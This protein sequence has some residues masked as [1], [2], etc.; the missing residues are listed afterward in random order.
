MSQTTDILINKLSNLSPDTV[1]Q[2]SQ[3]ATYQSLKQSAIELLEIIGHDQDNLFADLKME[4]PPAA[5]RQLGSNSISFDAVAADNPAA[6]A[7][8]ALQTFEGSRGLVRSGGNQLSLAGRRHIV[9]CQRTSRAK[10]TVLVSRNYLI[11]QDDETSRK[12]YDLGSLDKTDALEV[13]DLLGKPEKYPKGRSLRFPPGHH[14]N[15]TK[16]TRWLFADSEIT[17]EYQEEINTEFFKMNINKYNK[18]LYKAYKAEASTKKGTTLEDVCE[19]LFS[20]FEFISVRDRNLYTKSDEIDLVLEYTGSEAHNL[21]DYHSRFIPVECKNIES[22]VSSKQVSHFIQKIRDAGSTIGVLVA[23]NGVS[24]QDTGKNAQRYIDFSNNEEHFVVVLTS[25]DLYKIL[26][27][28]SLYD[29]IDRK[30][31]ELRFDI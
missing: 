30:I 25:H 8:I 6:P 19:F 2:N 28:T 1:S 22:T 4:V 15:Q 11:I 29:I 31:Y 5:R 7:Y 18:Q 16:L 3:K 12:I 9:S 20:G 23:W 21:F 13:I 27:G 10:Y 14:P 26:D 17:P 24:G